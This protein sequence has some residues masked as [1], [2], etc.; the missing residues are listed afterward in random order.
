MYNRTSLTT[1]WCNEQLVRVQ[2]DQVPHVHIHKAGSDEYLQGRE[3]VMQ[4]GPL[5][6]PVS[7]GSRGIVLISRPAQCQR[8]KLKYF[9]MAVKFLRSCVA[10]HSLRQHER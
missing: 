3:Y 6:R 2:E 1:V 5:I 10:R 9:L 8:V 4:L 7:R